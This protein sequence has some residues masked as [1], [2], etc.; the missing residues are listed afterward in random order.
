VN[1]RYDAIVL[2]AGHNGLVA[3]AVLARSGMDVLVL[4]K[5][6]VMGGAASTEE[7]WPGFKVDV[8]PTDA[9]QFRRK[10]IA[11]L[12]L[13]RFGLAFLQGA[14]FAHILRKDDFP[15]SVP[16]DLS[17]AAE[18]LSELS[19]A[20]AGAFGEFCAMMQGMTAILEPILSAPPP[21]PPKT[22]Q[23]RELTP[24]IKPILQLRRQDEHITA[25]LLRAIPMPIRDLLDDWFETPALKG[26]LA[27]FGLVGSMRGP[28][29]PGTV[30]NLLYQLNGR[31]SGEKGLAAPLQVVGGIGRLCE[32]I[33][34]V[35]QSAG[36]DIR[37][38]SEVQNISLSDGKAA[39]VQLADGQTI[40]A[41][42]VLASLSPG[43]TLTKLISPEHLSL[44]TMRRL[45]NLRYR[46]S[47]AKLILGLAALPAFPEV[48]Q[49]TGNI[50]FAPTMDY[51]ERAHDDA[52]YGKPSSEPILRAIMPTILDPS[53]APDGQHILSIQVQYVPHSFNGHKSLQD[54]ERKCIRIL[55][56]HAPGLEDL[57]I[58]KKFITPSDWEEEYGLPEGSIFH[59]QMD[60]DQLLL[61][62]PIPGYARYS[63][64]IPNLYFCGSGTHPGGG[65]T[66][67]PGYLGAKQAL[68]A[69]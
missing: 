29:S 28:Y 8:G 69:I 66:G 13:E 19:A 50:I 68:R 25:E 46:G 48:E 60:L 18:Q 12:D 3:A 64:P 11:E 7:L 40:R 26:A 5:R 31:V 51:I 52:K 53:L 22:L 42:I 27:A 14:Q 62:R 56:Q 41:E 17:A 38:E 6:T 2:G 54:L 4:E 21:E 32:V 43:Q 16:A 37:T 58:H 61:M 1:D 10:I 35:V 55:E 59:G 47:L 63:S 49:M 39:G 23:L 20:D 45:R 44:N 36:G 30:F 24:W 33:A 65:V 67:L 57:I 15:L 34:A 9:S